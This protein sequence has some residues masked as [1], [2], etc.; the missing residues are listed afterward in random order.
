M[1]D[2][3]RP[4]TSTVSSPAVGSDTDE[5][6]SFDEDELELLNDLLQP[7]SLPLQLGE[8]GFQTPGLQMETAK[9]TLFE[10]QYTGIDKPVPTGIFCYL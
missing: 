2:A 9:D 4:N 8:N 1:L 3:T 6:G 7:H 10:V 5:Y